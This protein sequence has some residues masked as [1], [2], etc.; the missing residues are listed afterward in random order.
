MRDNGGVRRRRAAAAAAGLGLA[1]A[2]AL[3][4]AALGR[5]PAVLRPASAA[6]EVSAAYRCETPVGPQE[7]TVRLTVD[8]PAEGA[9]GR[10]VELRLTVRELPVTLPVLVPAGGL[11]PS[12]VLR[13]SGAHTEPVRL[14]GAA[15]TEDLPADRP[16]AAPAMTGRFT[17]AAPGEITLTPDR[18]TL[19]A[20][21]P[22]AGAT[23]TVCTPVGTAPA[24]ATVRVSG[25]G[26]PSDGYGDGGPA[27][28]PSPDAPASGG[29]PRPSAEPSA[30]PASG[31]AP[32]PGPGVPSPAAPS[33]APSV[34][35]SGAS[36]P[37][38]TP[39]P[40]A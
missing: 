35:A 33:P 31:P 15:N 36:G 16:L 39:G 5:P 4:G 29:A 3:L 28:E 20:D 37:P 6:G 21:L 30:A 23:E 34:P 1:A 2:L 17:P 11:R 14:D 19:A 9:P 7:G 12:A 18:I 24:A 22:L 13:A 38:G 10:P 26:R 8:A 40:A 25:E 27:D 32:T